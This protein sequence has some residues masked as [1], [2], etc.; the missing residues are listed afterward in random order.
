M[1]AT[2]RRRFR[3]EFNLET[4]KLTQ[5]PFYKEKCLQPQL[6]S[7]SANLIG[8]VTVTGPLFVPG[9]NGDFFVAFLKETNELP[10]LYG[11]GMAGY[12]NSGRRRATF[13]AK[14][15]NYCIFSRYQPDTI[16]IRHVP[17]R[18][19]H[20]FTICQVACF[21][22]LWTV[23]SIKSTSIL[24]PIMLVVMVAVRKVIERFFTVNDLKY[25]DD[26]M[27]DFH[28]RKKEDL[29]RRMSEVGHS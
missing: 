27:P 6:D 13:P 3:L 8:L 29:K 18:R 19:I 7:N 26:P 2:K 23:K 11:C 12:R 16:Y 1:K 28:L 24:F 4:P 10:R 14:N 9:R 20:L 22:M 21:A 17:I 15:L 25:L 5:P